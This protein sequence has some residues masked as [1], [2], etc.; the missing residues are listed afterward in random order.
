[1]TDT[2]QRYGVHSVQHLVS[3]SG[4]YRAVTALEGAA[5]KTLDFEQTPI[6]VVPLAVSD[7]S[8]AGSTLAP[9]ANRLADAT[10]SLDGET[11]NGEITEPNHHNGLHGLLVR[12][13]FEIVAQASDAITY[14]YEFGTDAVYPFKVVFEVSYRLTDSGL[15]VS[16][17]ATNRADKKLPISIG[18]HPYFAV[19]ADSQFKTP[20]RKVAVNDERQLPIGEQSVEAIKLKTGEFTSIVDRE[21]DD[22]LFELGLNAETVLTRPSIGKSVVIWQDE[23]MPYQ[24]I[25][26]RS[27][28]FAGTNPITVA[29]EPQSSPANA[30]I[31]GT[32]LIWM[33]PGETK[34][35]TWGV[36]V[37]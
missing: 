37:S 14:R 18:T 11:F 32:D 19:D 30:L 15:H 31:S 22:C 9:W 20:A 3:P 34:I 36:R 29:I 16:M 7:F 24:M 4:N 10:W 35:A 25:F 26:V 27:P 5:L 6:V 23:S 8:F 2:Y 21:L 33:T 12:R 1:M 13:D 17:A 28:R